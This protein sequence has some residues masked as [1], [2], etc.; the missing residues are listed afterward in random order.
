MIVRFSSFADRNFVWG[1]R[2]SLKGTE[3]IVREDLP[4]AVERQRRILLSVYLHAKRMDKSIKLL[5]RN[6]AILHN[7][8]VYNVDNVFDLIKLLKLESIA[9][10]DVADSTLFSGRHSM[11]SNFSKTPFKLFDIEFVSAEQAY[12]YGKALN[13]GDDDAAK[14]IKDEKDSISIKRIGDK[15]KSGRFWAQEGAARCMKDVLMAKF[16]Q[17]EMAKDVLLNTKTNIVEC[18]KYDSYFGIGKPLHDDTAH[19]SAKWKGKNVLGIL[20]Q[21]VRD[22]IK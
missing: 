6:D 18:N 13:A 11:L 20:L 7:G 2:F 19:I 14:K 21:E 17:C 22:H 16:D 3:C 10:R 15:V 12:Q 9:Q 5:L 4:E 1:K 8:I